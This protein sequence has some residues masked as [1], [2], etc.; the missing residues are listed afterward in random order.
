MKY[1]FDVLELSWSKT[2]T[3]HCYSQT[4]TKLNQ[5]KVKKKMLN[6][7]NREF[8]FKSIRK[9]I[10]ASDT[11]LLEAMAR[12]NYKDF[13]VLL[14]RMDFLIVKLKY[15]TMFNLCSNENTIDFYVVNHI[16]L[17]TQIIDM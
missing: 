2:S 6:I 13:E 17:S 1:I 15:N 4:L 9:L 10:T 3:N 7:L 8:F 12:E 14:Q 5:N 16:M 11:G